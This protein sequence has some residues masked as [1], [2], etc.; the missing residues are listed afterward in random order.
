[1]FLHS[2]HIATVR[3]GL[4]VAEDTMLNISAFYVFHSMCIINRFDG[5]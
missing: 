4:N 5:I 1:M 3:K 2:K